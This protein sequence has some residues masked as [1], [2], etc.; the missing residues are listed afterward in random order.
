MTYQ[1]P[2]YRPAAVNLTQAARIA[3]MGRTKFFLLLR[4]GLGP[5]VHQIEGHR[6]YILYADLMAW[7]KEKQHE[8]RRH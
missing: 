2:L 1:S 4:K 7:L 6:P 3:G 8:R 5:K